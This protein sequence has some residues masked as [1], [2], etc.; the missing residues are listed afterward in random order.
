MIICSQFGN[1][2]AGQD[3][4]YIKGNAYQKEDYPFMRNR[5]FIALLLCLTL[6][7]GCSN[8]LAFPPGGSPAPQEA[9]GESPTPTE[10]A[11]TTLPM[12]ADA[13]RS[14]PFAAI[15]G[16]TIYWCTGYGV[17]A[18][19]AGGEA[20][21]F[22]EV[23]GA[24]PLVMDGYLYIVEDE[25]DVTEEVAWPVPAE[26]ATASNILRIPLSGGEAEKI[27]TAPYINT[28]AALD[29]RLYFST[30]QGE[31]LQEAGGLF[32]IDA[33][34]G[35][36]RLLAEDCLLV[37]ALG[38]GYAYY[39]GVAEEGSAFFRISL[40]GGEGERLLQGSGTPVT[41]LAYGGDIY[42]IFVSWV[43]ADAESNLAIMRLRDGKSETLA[44]GL[45][46][47]E[48]LGIWD[49]K[50]YYASVPGAGSSTSALDCCRHR[51]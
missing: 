13:G 28:I 29:G 34:G 5:I 33:G 44:P 48:L 47:R 6:A 31:A 18:M 43:E 15:D 8:P 30:T 3:M 45:T 42:Y 25:T 26:A 24:N 49:G 46:A 36:E 41:P 17:L 38:D 35:D 20:K 7:A 1:G 11:P 37:C 10:P 9:A 40:A 22:S 12:A 50:L 51:T 27:Y 23:R 16:D 2:I 14:F 19:A 39:M 32:S 21:L 4:L